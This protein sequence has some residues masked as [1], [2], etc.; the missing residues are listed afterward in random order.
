MVNDSE[1][2]DQGLFEKLTKA[3]EICTVYYGEYPVSNEPVVKSYIKYLCRTLSHVSRTT[4]VV[5]HTGSFLF[6]VINIAVAAVYCLVMNE[7]TPQELLDTFEVGQVVLYKGDRHLYGGQCVNDEGR[8]CFKIKKI[9]ANYSDTKL[10]SRAKYMEPYYG[11]STSLNKMG[12]RGEIWDNR[13]LFHEAVAGDVNTAAFVS[14][15]S[16]VVV[17]PNSGA[18]TRDLMNRISFKINDT[19]VPVLHL[20]RA[21]Y[22]TEENE[23]LFA[24]NAGKLEPNLKFT[25]SVYLGRKKLL[26][27]S[28]NRNIGILVLGEE[29]FAKAENGL[30][31]V[32]EHEAAQFALA[33]ATM[34]MGS[35][36]A[37]LRDHQD[38]H[39]YFCSRGY[40]ESDPEFMEKKEDNPYT[41]ELYGQ[42]GA[43]TGRT[44]TPVLVEDAIGKEN[45]VEIRNMIAIFT[46]KEKEMLQ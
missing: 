32:I 45:V 5:F 33:S 26:E 17:T 43:I 35:K 12:L 18:Q 19:L 27:R 20:V 2:V 36:E 30:D 21:S 1:P 16:V 4:D 13:L 15:K 37:F 10:V 29:F 7:L 34:S 44:V 39:F 42:M 40:L 8:Q 22:F 9:K 6:D 11:E 28:D 41:A 23:R 24:G 46:E 25:N 38:A 3:F 14:D 31:D